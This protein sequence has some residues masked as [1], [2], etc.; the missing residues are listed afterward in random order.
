MVRP[1]RYPVGPVEGLAGQAVVL[2]VLSMTISIGV[3]GWAVGLAYGLV[4]CLGLAYGL[5]R[6]GASRLGPADWLT[7]TRALLV[8]GVA[9]LVAHGFRA[10][11]PVAVLVT[12][13]SVA[14]V[15]DNI[16]GRVARRTGTAT[17]LGARFDMEIDAFLILVLSVHVA[18]SLGW[19][20]LAI[21]LMRY[22]YVVAG[23][24]LP[25]LRSPV[26]PRNWRRVVAAVQGVVLT[27]AASD[28]F[29][30]LLMIV[31]VAVALAMLIESFGRDIV[32]QHR[33]R[34]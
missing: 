21:G 20:V 2:A 8:G 34:R 3:E 22:V 17:A 12:I 25:W 13:T 5:H 14:L 15:L 32:W 7:L 11:V 19:W 28:L 6:A 4:T 26:P 31:A 9:A 1:L 18:R 27:V 23:W 16:D 33:S 10:P 30:R 24:L 29:P